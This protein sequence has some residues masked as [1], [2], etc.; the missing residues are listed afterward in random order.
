MTGS[1]YL[2]VSQMLRKVQSKLVSSKGKVSVKLPGYLKT[3]ETIRNNRELNLS[4]ETLQ[5]KVFFLK[6][7]ELK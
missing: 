1:E 2:T 5:S 6:K 3:V 4:S 7:N